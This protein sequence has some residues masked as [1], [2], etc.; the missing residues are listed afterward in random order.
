MP[1]RILRDGILSSP[2]VNALSPGA[3]ILYR[4]LM[5]VVDDYGRFYGE[6]GPVRGACWPV[7]SST[8]C[9]QDVGKWLAECG[10][11]ADNLPAGTKQLISFYLVAGAMY[12][13]LND[14]NQKTRSK[15]KY[16]EPCVQVA[17]NLSTECGQVADKKPALVGIRSSYFV[18]RNSEGEPIPELPPEGRSVPPAKINSQDIEHDGFDLYGFFVQEY[19][20]VSPVPDDLW[21]RFGKYVDGES[22]H[23][24]R[25]NLLSYTQSERY[26]QFAP[27]PEKFLREKIF[28]HPAPASWKRAEADE[29]APL[30]AIYDPAAEE[31]AARDE[32]TYMRRMSRK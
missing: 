29:P 2:R 10:Q 27:A 32:A 8:I 18:I 16:P 4:R 28:K 9:E 26:Q 3:E 30:M 25:N 15:I 31:Q 22:A 20:K 13:Q 7:N 19:G 24:L 11:V 6:A 1:S 5:S 12:L 17:D 14:F 21:L 23:L